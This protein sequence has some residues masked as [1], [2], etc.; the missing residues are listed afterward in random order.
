MGR[1]IFFSLPISPNNFPDLASVGR[2]VTGGIG[3]DGQTCN[4]CTITTW[5]CMKI[6]NPTNTAEIDFSYAPK[7]I[8]TSTHGTDF[9][10]YWNNAAQQCSNL[11][12]PNSTAVAQSG[13]YSDLLAHAPF[14]GLSSPKYIEYRDGFGTFFHM[15]WT[16]PAD[17]NQQEDRTFSYDI[18]NSPKRR[19]VY[20][21]VGLVLSS[22]QFR[23]GSVTFNG[24][25]QLSSVTVNNGG[26][27]IKTI[28]FYQSNKA[29]NNLT[30]ARSYNGNSFNGTLY[31]DSISVTNSASKY[32]TYAFQYKNKYCFGDHLKGHDAWGYVNNTTTEIA[33]VTTFPPF[34]PPQTV[35][36]SAYN[37]SCMYT[38][39]TVS[40]NG[41]GDEFPSEYLMQSGM[42]SSISY[43]TGGHA[44]F[45]FE[46]NRYAVSATDVNGPSKRL[47]L[48]GGLRI[49]KITYYDG[50]NLNTPAKQQYFTYG[51]LEDGEGILLNPPGIKNV[52]GSLIYGNYSFTQ[53][54][55]YGITSTS[56]SAGSATGEI[57]GFVQPCMS[58]NCIYLTAKEDKT[59]YLPNSA[60]DLTY[61][62]GSPIYYNK[63]TEYQLD[64]GRK[65]GKSVYTYYPVDYFGIGFSSSPTI[66]AMILGTDDK[67]LRESWFMGKL[68][69][70]AQ[71][72]YNYSLGTFSMVHQN[73]YEYTTY[74]LSQ[75][76]RVIYSFLHNF[77]EVSTSSA[78]AQ[79]FY[80]N[81]PYATGNF[82]TSS[83]NFIF[84]E[85]GIPAGQLLISKKTEQWA[86][87]TND[88]LSYTTQYFYNNP[89]YLQ[90][91]ST[92][93][94]DSKQVSRTTVLKYPYDYPTDPV[95]AA[96][97][98]KN[99]ISPVIEQIVSHGNTPEYSRTRINYA[100]TNN[101]FYV[102]TSRQTSF[103]GHALETETLFSQYDNYGNLLEQTGRDGI[104]H[105]FLWGYSSR[106]PVAGITGMSY[107]A[108]VSGA[109][110]NQTILDAPSS[111]V[112][113]A[114]ELNKL[115]AIPGAP[116]LV[117]SFTYAPMTGITS[118][119]DP[120]GI[121]NYFEYD[122][123]SRLI[124]V[125]DNNHNLTK[126]FE[127]STAGPSTVPRLTTNRPMMIT[128][129]A[130][131]PLSITG[132]G[133][134]YIVPG[135]TEVNSGDYTADNDQYA[136]LTTYA[137]NGAVFS[138][139]TNDTSN[140]AAI[141][142]LNTQIFLAGA[143]NQRPYGMMVEF[144]QNGNVVAS[145]P[146]AGDD[147]TFKYIYMPEGDYQLSFRLDP[148]FRYKAMKFH[149]TSSDGQLGAFTVSGTTIT[150]KRK[151][152]YQIQATNFF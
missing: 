71:Y 146:F 152:T 67:Y 66:S 28:R 86:D 51:D 138:S 19:S 42:L 18:L 128:V 150:L 14:Q 125:R 65:A 10:E 73:N 17:N 43:P 124:N 49:Q 8:T 141:I 34:Y 20:S 39:I 15:I 101:W 13:T 64:Y 55:Y 57:P 92:V 117:K 143:G 9:V 122:P 109:S 47:L 33:N 26:Q 126:R 5:K 60:L 54:V 46:A 95:Y 130:C 63:V 21:E 82:S 3:T 70:E 100:Y 142:Q 37:S 4:G 84:S 76:P 32:E 134:N 107:N 23:G 116:A 11:E 129:C 151:V 105:S 52:D 136:F 140:H 89:G 119:T 96:M 69:S 74:W 133:N 132:P 110:I 145:E 27:E 148:S 29:P 123:F 120:Q 41:S 85:D 112:Q 1:I 24:T 35:S 36:Q 62:G 50:I 98:A 38:P 44:D 88:T 56:L 61:A 22:I 113:L 31:L 12:F 121:S 99:M 115:R 79:D 30:M 72:K 45:D 25:D 77:Y 94:I 135:G 137:G 78:N 53:T 127:Y 87:D 68:K 144:I 59:T 118:T 97:V 114:T 6:V 2:E 58:N 16:N 149:V 90:P 48:G 104:T 7:S 147:A 103:G 83:N 80:F 108:A 131:V 106:Y 93:T 81:T 91:T 75:W 40:L 102:P 139:C 111:D